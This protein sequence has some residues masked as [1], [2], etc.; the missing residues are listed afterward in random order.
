MLVM[1]LKRVFFNDITNNFIGYF[2]RTELSRI[3]IEK[4]RVLFLFM[5]FI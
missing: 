2:N 4:W 3:Y 5:F 1:A